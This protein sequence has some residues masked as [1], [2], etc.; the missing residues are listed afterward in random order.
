MQSQPQQPPEITGRSLCQQT[1]AAARSAGLS[2]LVARI[3][4]GRVQ[5]I[6][7]SF[8]PFLK[9]S[10]SYLDDP[11][12]LSDMNTA[13]NRLVEAIKGGEKIGVVT[14]YDVDGITSHTLIRETL[15]QD[16][17]VPDAQVTGF[18]GH[19]L[20]EGYGLSE[21]VCKR[22]LAVAPAVVITAD[23]GSSDE[24]RIAVLK[25]AGIDVIV[26]DH[27]GFPAAGPPASALAT[28]SPAHPESRYPDTA[29]AG[30]TVAWL[31]MCMVRAA[32]IEAGVIDASAPKLTRHLD[33]VSLGTV[34]DAV[35]LFSSNNRALVMAGLAIMNRL[36]R[37][38]WQALANLLERPPQVPF[39]IDDL[40]FQ[41]GPRINAR[42]RMEDPFAAWHFLAATEQNVARQLLLELDDNNRQRR[43]MEKSMVQSAREQVAA[44]LTPAQQTIVVYDDTYHA[45]VQG[46]VASRLLDSF[47]RVTCVMSPG[48][49]AGLISGSLRSVAAVD[50]GQA[51]REVHKRH[52]RL[53]HR[54][55][56]H[57]A[58]AG[59]SVP[60]A[61]LAQFQAALDAAV[62]DQLGDTLLGP[63]LYSDGELAADELTLTTWQELQQLS[64]YGRGF[65]KPLFDGMFEVLQ[66]RAVGADPVHLSLN[67]RAGQ[68]K[69]RGIWFSALDAAGDTLPFS[70]GSA[71]RC[72]YELQPDSYRGGAA[73]QLIVRHARAE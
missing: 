53:L 33:L 12:L 65:E 4:A 73:M 68:H 19:R 58:A 55:G 35:S 21:P 41:I 36:E 70:N 29:I 8:A 13:R 15:V 63:V 61:Q 46:I 57:R 52:P 45:G 62:A 6:D 20:T 28:V 54:F 22:V 37:P 44:T 50:V 26:T 39:S 30:C 9:P 40:G 16:F 3:I 56:G 23:C 59:V 72:V 69:V 47:G 14:D 10:L 24:A 42:G 1:L 2:D 5:N 64:P 17:G 7:G 60:V 31:L 11:L 25:A 66:V 38:C 27:H 67:L 32:L 71:I 18:I 43:A 34:A 49:E 51:L 48:S